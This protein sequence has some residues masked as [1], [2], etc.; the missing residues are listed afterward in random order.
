MDTIAARIQQALDQKGWKQADLVKATLYIYNGE[1]WV[2]LYL[3]WLTAQEKKMLAEYHVRDEGP[4]S[5]VEGP[6][7][8]LKNFFKT[9]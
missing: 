1:Q 3:P 5:V 9:P 2:R 7:N 8:F 6:K 4:I